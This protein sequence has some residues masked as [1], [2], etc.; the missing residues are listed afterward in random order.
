MHRGVKW[1]FFEAVALLRPMSYP[2]SFW[3]M[4]SAID[5][6]ISPERIGDILP[7]LES[8][9]FQVAVKPRSFSDGSIGTEFLVREN[10]HRATVINAPPSPG[11]TSHYLLCLSNRRNNDLLIKVVEALRAAGAEDK[12]R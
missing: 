5:L 2:F 7:I 3:N 6:Y 10:S 4:S 12:H 8:R 9:G 1:T 11:M